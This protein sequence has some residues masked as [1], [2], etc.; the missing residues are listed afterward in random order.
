MYQAE[1]ETK[2][3]SSEK[4]IVDALRHLVKQQSVPDIELDVFDTNPLDFHCF[5][6]PFH[7]VVEKRIDSPRGRLGSNTQV[8][9]QKK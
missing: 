2:G 4:N 1:Q 7:E 6:T 5:M 9:M 3:I 8:G